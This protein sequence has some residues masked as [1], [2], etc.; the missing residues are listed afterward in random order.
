M[1][2]PEIRALLDLGPAR[3]GLPAAEARLRQPLPA[4]LCRY[5]A[6]VGNPYANRL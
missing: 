3:Y 5:Y 2:F 1:S 6:A 4:V